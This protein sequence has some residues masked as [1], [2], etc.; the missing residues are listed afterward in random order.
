M[1][2]ADRFRLLGRYRTPRVRVGTVL[3]C[4][5]RDCE[6]IVVGYSDGKIPWPVG[7]RKGSGS[8]GLIVFGGLAKAVGR[9][10]AQAV[11]HWWGV[12]RSSV[13]RW[14]MALGVEL[15]N[16]G[17][18]RLRS[19]YTREPW[20]VK[21]LRKGTQAARSPE[22]RRKMGE[23]ARGKPRPEHVREAVGRANKRRKV[24]AATRARMSAAQ[25]ARVARGAYHYPTGKPWRKWEDELVRKLPVATAAK[26]TRRSLSNVYSRRGVLKVSDGRPSQDGHWSVECGK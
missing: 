16:P 5:A 10:S 23:A 25:R 8:R 17:T 15:A 7:R 12:G 13:W 21:A 24:G 4:E 19:D 20:A 22:T 2:D 9:E 18:H 11:R 1:K 6:V 14:R 3:S 26:H